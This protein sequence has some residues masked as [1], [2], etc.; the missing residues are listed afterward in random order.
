MRRTGIATLW[1]VSFLL[2]HELAWSIFGSPRL[3]GLAIGF[4][5]AAFVLIDPL[6]I[7]DRR[8]ARAAA[9]ARRRIDALTRLESAPK[10]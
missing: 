5:A 8:P 6:G 2:F 4:A 3:L 1:F 10:A 9:I 7:V